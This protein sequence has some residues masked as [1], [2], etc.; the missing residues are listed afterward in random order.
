MFQV[1]ACLPRRIVNMWELQLGLCFDVELQ[2]KRDP[3]EPISTTHWG[4][5]IWSGKE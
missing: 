5:R 4:V 3:R 2:M 1:G